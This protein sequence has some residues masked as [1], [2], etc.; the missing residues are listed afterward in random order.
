MGE[1]VVVVRSDA[2]TDYDLGDV[3]HISVR[4][5]GEDSGGALT[6]FEVSGEVVRSPD[7]ARLHLHE[8][9][10]EV[11]YLLEGSVDLVTQDQRELDLGPGSIIVV[12]PGVAHGLAPNGRWRHVT[13][14][15]PGGYDRYFAE[16]ADA[17]ADHGPA[18][19]RTTISARYGT[20][21]VDH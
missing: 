18:A 20:Y 6:V 16:V 14:V 3:T 17:I 11:F 8:D 10:T 5:S 1:R 12:P 21:P 9:F 15:I 13:F 19:D 4:L 2:G 7:D